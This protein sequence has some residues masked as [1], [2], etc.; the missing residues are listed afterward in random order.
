MAFARRA[1]RPW[2]FPGRRAAPL[3][4]SKDGLPPLPIGEVTSLFA[5][6]GTRTPMQPA[7]SSNRANALCAG[8][9]GG[10]QSSGHSAYS[11][12]GRENACSIVSTLGCGFMLKRMTVA[13][14]ENCAS[15]AGGYPTKISSL[16]VDQVEMPGCGSNSA[17]DGK[18]GQGRAKPRGTE[19]PLG[20]K[21]AGGGAISG[22]RAPC[23][24]DWTEVVTLYD[25][26]SRGSTSDLSQPS[27]PQALLSADLDCEPDNPSHPG[28]FGSTPGTG[29]ATW[30]KGRLMVDAHSGSGRSLRGSQSAFHRKQVSRGRVQ[31]WFA[32]W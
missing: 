32:V 10:T 7:P 28:T 13:S 24:C 22:K 30:R 8:H 19:V 5:A 14:L 1:P 31:H 27:G 11:T 16:A 20:R 12:P 2:G 29:C 6:D 3:T 15:H 17:P 9:F 21:V 4:L 18:L 23:C 25:E 26:A